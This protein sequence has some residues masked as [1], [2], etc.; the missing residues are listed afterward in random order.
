MTEVPEGSANSRSW[1]G[2]RL[3]AL[4]LVTVFTWRKVSLFPRL[5]C[6]WAVPSR[7]CYLPVILLVIKGHEPRKPC[8]L[9][10]LDIVRQVN[11]VR[12]AEPEHY[13]ARVIADERI[14]PE[15]IAT[16]GIITEQPTA[17]YVNSPAPAP[18]HRLHGRMHRSDA[19]FS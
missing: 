18:V 15:D 17:T 13:P 10:H 6:K 4:I 1:I 14:D 11:G 8:A 9:S 2:I 19:I 7:I 5:C 12:F 16:R 3:P